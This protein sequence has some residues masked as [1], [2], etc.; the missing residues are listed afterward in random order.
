MD[1]S[2]R[3]MSQPRG[4]RDSSVSSAYGVGGGGGGGTHIKN[5]QSLNFSTKHVYQKS[6]EIVGLMGILTHTFLLKITISDR[7]VEFLVS[8]P[9]PLSCYWSSVH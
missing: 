5:D 6:T 3:S 2:V 8:A 7:H 4:K 9:N 1:R